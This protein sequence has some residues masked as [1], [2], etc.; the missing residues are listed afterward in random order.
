M[1]IDELL[2]LLVLSV[3]FLAQV[4]DNQI[5]LVN[6]L[7][8][9]LGKRYD[10]VVAVRLQLRLLNEDPTGRARMRTRALLT[11]MLNHLYSADHFH[12]ENA[13]HKEEWT[14]RLM[15]F[16]LLLN[17]PGLALLKRLALDESVLALSL[18]I[19]APGDDLGVREYFLAAVLGICALE[20]QTLELL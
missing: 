7:V 5:F 10:A 3:E 20:F 8:K 6:R 17:T 19:V 13:R 12:A 14:N 9:I 11:L 2:D 15:L 1:F 4:V 16:D 18:R